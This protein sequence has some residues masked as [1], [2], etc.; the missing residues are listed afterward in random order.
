M[1]RKNFFLIM[2]IIFW[3]LMAIGF[4]DNWLFDIEQKS[5]SQPKFLIHA[6]FASCWFTLLVLQS[7]WIRKKDFKLHFK[8]G[9]LGIAIYYLMTLTIWYLYYEVF[10]IKNDW[11]KLLKPLETFSIILVTFGFINRRQNSQRHKEYIMFG[12]F[13]LIGPG[14]DRTV[15]HLFG[16]EYMIWPMLILN[17]I[18]FGFFIWYKKRLT[19]Y[20][21][22]WIIFWTY[23]LYPLISRII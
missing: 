17:W 13:C 19:W 21:G 23:S 11:L 20:M 16:P 22:L 14:L 10:V 8:V 15:F 7:M 4:S 2:S 18:L 3:L 5:N 1:K 6:F 12:T 9:L